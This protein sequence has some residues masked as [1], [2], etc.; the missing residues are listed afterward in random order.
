MPDA[1]K[2]RLHQNK[3]MM[4]ILVAI[5]HLHDHIRK[6][7]KSKSSGEAKSFHDIHEPASRQSEQLGRSHVHVMIIHGG[8]NAATPLLQEEVAHTSK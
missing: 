2:K 4:S 3:S 5:Y 6:Y 8:G 7:L 1:M